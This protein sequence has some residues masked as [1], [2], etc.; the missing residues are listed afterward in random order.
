MDLIDLYRDMY[1][2]RAFE[3]AQAELWHQGLISG[4]MH[5]G[6]GEEAIA[7]GVGAHMKKGDGV[8][9][10]HRSTPLLTVLG[11]DLVL[12]LRE[13]LG[14]EDGLCGGRG[15]H[16]HLFSKEHIAASSGIVGSGAPIGAGFALAARQLRPGSVGLGFGGDGAANMGM[17][18]EAQNLAVAWNLPMI[19]VCKDNG[20]AITTRSSSVTGGEL[21]KRAQAFGLAAW[22]V[23]GTDA[24]AVWN[25]A[26]EAF[27]R[28]RKG[29]GPGFL[30]FTCPRLDGHFIGDP[31]IRTAKSPLGEGG[32]TLG[33]IM[34]AALTRGGA[35]IGARVRSMSHM[36][37]TMRKATKD[38][39]ESK[40][41]PIVRCRRDLKKRAEEVEKIE[42]EIERRV[43]EAVEKA[44]ADIIKEEEQ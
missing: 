5:L 39:R 22:D 24:M 34:S 44:L 37:R 41:D 21:V 9:L 7:A 25:A 15:G 26:G 13:M 33:K 11:V 12:M 10:D 14:R 2:A 4:E 17:L 8:A 35:G 1:K 18:M 19:F 3:M 20:W 28:S 29:K 40:G 16:M 27:E 6:T 38:R 31:M 30:R 36:M 23:D 43:G 32:E 42:E